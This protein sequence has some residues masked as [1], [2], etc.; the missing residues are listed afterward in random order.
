MN[1]TEVY[2]WRLSQEMKSA[3]EEAARRNHKTVAKLLEYIVE[4]WLRETHP[5][6]NDAAEAEQRRLHL[7]AAK[8]LGSIQGGD[9]DRSGRVREELR[10]RIARRHGR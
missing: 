7:T 1:K 2:S 4:Q 6:E 8:A 10:A 5:A 3:L 9:P